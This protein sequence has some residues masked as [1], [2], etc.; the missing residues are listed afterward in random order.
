VVPEKAIFPTVTVC[1]KN[2]PSKCNLTVQIERVQDKVFYHLLVL[3][4]D[5]V[6]LLIIPYDLHCYKFQV[7][8]SLIN[9]K[10]NVDK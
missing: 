8:S 9:V 3:S 6:T 4:I 7:Y 10:L 1:N 5:N 2:V